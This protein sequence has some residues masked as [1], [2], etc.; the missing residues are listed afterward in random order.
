MHLE[1]QDD[2]NNFQPRV[3]AGSGGFGNVACREC[4]AGVKGFGN[5]PV[6]V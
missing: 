2:E 6:T 1:D 5:G 3:Q 4:G